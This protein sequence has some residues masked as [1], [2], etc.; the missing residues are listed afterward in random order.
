MIF[1]AA[2][3][4]LLLCAPLPAQD[5][6][7]AVP[8]PAQRYLDILSKRPQPGTLFER[9]Y[10]AWLE[11]GTV[12]EMQRF[13]EAQAAATGAPATAH[14]ILAIFHAH[15]GNDPEAL[16]C[17][18]TALRL[19]PQNAGAWIECSRIEARMLDFAAALQS[20]DQ[21]EGAKPQDQQKAEIGKLRGRALLRL[22][23]SDEALAV[24][25]ALASAH[26]DDEDLQEE[27]ID[28]FV[29]EGQ[30]EAALESARALV[31]RSRDPAAKI[32]R[33]LR[34]ADV[35]L[36]AERRD[37]ALTMLDSAFAATG[38]DS[39]IEGDILARIDRLFR[40][41]D[42]VSGLQ[43]HLAA[44][45]QAHPQRVTLAW[46]HAL[47]LAA[48]GQNDAALKSARALLQSNPGRRDLRDGFLDLLDSLG[49]PGEA[50]EQARLVVAQNPGDKE[51]LVR[52]A[53]LQHRAGDDSA[54]RLTLESFLSSAAADESAHLRIAR[55]LESW[56]E[57]P[58]K[59]DS[60]A[61]KAYLRLV[62]TFPQSLSAQEAHAHYLHRT[63]HRE[64]AI[65]IWRRM[66]GSAVLE[67]LL[68]IAQALQARLESRPALDVLLER[69]K[70]FSAQPRFL[71]LMVHL[72]MA[73]KEFG[74]ALP[75][76]CAH[77][78][79]MQDADGIDSSLRD[80]IAIVRSQEMSPA[81]PLID[82]LKAMSALTLQD[83]CLLAALLDHSG[84]TSEA[85]AL[86]NAAPA[87]DALIA[88][89]QL[90]HVFQS[91]Q[92]W[93][94][95][96]ETLRRVLELPGGRSSGNL[97]RMVELSRRALQPEQALTYIAEWKTV[98]PGAVAPWI[99]EARV[100][101]DLL[102]PEAALKALRLAL[103]KFPD[104]ADVAAAC[105][106]ACLNAGQA[107][108]AERIY[109]AMYEKTT[110]PASR[111]RML[112]PLA[113]A[114][115]SHDG[116]P[117]LLQNFVQRQKQNR[118]SAYPWLALAEIHRATDND[119][120]RRRCLYEASRLRPHDL[121]LLLEIAR[122][123][124]EEGLTPEAL[125]T[126]EAA[127]KLDKTTQT[128]EH[129]A[130]LQIEDGDPDIGYRMLFDLADS[131][132]DARAVEQMALVIGMKGDWE[133]VSSFL[134]PLLEKHP[135][136]Y[137]L[138]YLQA[139]ALEEAG[140]EPEAVQAFLRVLAMHE[141]L[142]SSR[143]AQQQQLQLHALPQ[144]LPSGT[145]DWLA[146][147]NIARTAYSYREER[148]H[149][150]LLPP[151]SGHGT[152]SL[153]ALPADVTESPTFALV[154][155]LQIT[156]VWQEDA[157]PRLTKQLKREGVAHA[158]LLLELA[159]ES[160]DF[161]VC[162]EM[163]SAHPQDAALHAA[164]L[165]DPASEDDPADKL[166]ACQR[167]FD[168][169]KGRHG[170]LALCAADTA[171]DT[172]ETPADAAT[173]LQLV[174]DLC[175]AVPQPQ[176]NEHLVLQNLLTSQ[177]RDAHESKQAPLVLISP[178]QSQTIAAT[179]RRWMQGMD[180]RHLDRMESLL[181]GFFELK[182]W[183]DVIQCL[184]RM[185]QLAEEPG[186]P[187]AP[188]RQSVRRSSSFE[189]S[190]LGLEATSCHLPPFVT[191]MLMNALEFT[192]QQADRR[193]GGNTVVAEFVEAMKTRLA[194][195]SEPRLKFILSML[196]G[197]GETLLTEL[198]P[199][200]SSPEAT[201]E[202]FFTAGWIC[203]E[204]QQHEAA[205][206]RFLKAYKTALTPDARQQAA[207]A[208]L[209]HAKLLGGTGKEETAVAAVQEMMRLALQHASTRE[210][211]E[212]LAGVMEEYGMDA[213][214][215]KLRSSLP[216]LHAVAASQSTTAILNPYSQALLQRGTVDGREALDRHLSQNNISGALNEARRVVRALTAEWLDPAR[217]SAETAEKLT[218]LLL[219]LEVQQL[220]QTLL[221]GIRNAAAN[222]WKPR[223][224]HAA[225][226]DMQ[227]AHGRP[228]QNNDGD[229]TLSSEALFEHAVAGYIT[230]LEANPHA[231]AA[232]QRLVMLHAASDA[233]TALKHWLLLP[234]TQQHP[235]LLPLT[236]QISGSD[237]D[238]ARSLAAA[239]LV[240]QWIKNRPPTDRLPAR[241]IALIGEVLDRVQ[242]GG[243]SFPSWW[244]I[245]DND[246]HP[247]PSQQGLRADAPG[248]PQ[249]GEDARRARNERRIAHDALC[250]AMIALPELAE[251][252]FA[253]LAGLAMHEGRNIEETEK[254]AP[255]ILSR[256]ADRRGRSDPSRRRRNGSASAIISKNCFQTR[257]RIAMPSPAVFAT[258]SAAARGDVQM[259]EGTLFPIILKTEGQPMLDFCRGYAGL[260]MAGDQDFPKA[261]AE[262]LRP[263]S[264][265]AGRSTLGCMAGEIVRL[266][267]ARKFTT[268]L[269]DFIIENRD[270]TLPSPEPADPFAARPEAS[271]LDFYVQVL[272][273]R[274]PE[275]LPRFIRRL[276]SVWVSPEAALRQKA[277]EK[278][279]ETE[280][281]GSQPD[282]TPLERAALKYR[283]WLQHFINESEGS[284]SIVATALEEDSTEPSFWLSQM[285]AA[286]LSARVQTP[287]EFIRLT[288]ALGFLDPA[289][290]SHPFA[291]AR[292]QQKDLMVKLA[293]QCRD[294]Q[295]D[296]VINAIIERLGKDHPPS[297]TTHW[298]QAMLVR[299]GITTLWLDG[300]P[301]K[302]QAA[303]P[304][305]EKGLCHAA[306]R[307]LLV[308]HAAEIA[309][310]PTDERLNLEAFLKVQL[311]DFPH[312]DIADA[313]FKHAVAPILK[314][315]SEELRHQADARLACKTWEEF[316]P[317]GSSPEDLTGFLQTVAADDPGRARA[318]AEHGL[319]LL[320]GCKEQ[321][322]TMGEGL[323]DTPASRYIMSLAHVPQLLGTSLALAEKHGLH[324]S[325]SW[326]GNECFR[327]EEALKKPNSTRWVFQNTPFTAAA[328]DFRDMRVDD[329][330]EPT[331]LARIIDSLEQEQE[332][333]AR[334][335]Q[336]LAGQPST[337]GTQLLLALL[338]RDP[339]DAK[340][341][342]SFYNEPHR[343]DDSRIITFIRQHRDDFT[344]L[345]PET[346]TAVLALFQARIPDLRSRSAADPRLKASLQPLI[347]AD[348]RQFE[349]DLQQFLKL[350]S[351]QQ[352]GFG[353]YEATQRGL[354]FLDRLAP[355]DKARAVELLDHVSKLM[356]TEEIIARSKGRLAPP[357]QTRIAQ[358][359]QRAAATPELFEEIMQRANE[360][361]A[362]GNP[363]WMQG[364]LTHL[365]DLQHLQ[366]SPQRFVSLL[367]A[368]H[369][370]DPAATFTPQPMPME[371]ERPTLLENWLPAMLQWPDLPPLLAKVRPDSFGADLLRLLLIPGP[372]DQ[373]TA[374]FAV[375]HEA[376]IAALP[377]A[378]QKLIS[379]LLRRLGVDKLPPPQDER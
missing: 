166:A 376:E 186:L 90:S 157:Q 373:E 371:K 79:L 125:R 283:D 176:S 34:L 212:S 342:R 180:N 73:N 151:G 76:A 365:M 130:R 158:E 375:K 150:A 27:I 265:S 159:R 258:W 86:L 379:E 46:Q 22:G 191:G 121:T 161:H 236:R 232:R 137:R 308:R 255:Q 207:N 63:G 3:C 62:A 355:M 326:C 281:N 109:L 240:T 138:H 235:L 345:T 113:K 145:A 95:A 182:A 333:C 48:T 167:C 354:R 163:L 7:P 92:D 199:R 87:Q 105:A 257:N 85:Q 106:T 128:R 88:L 36:L 96:A 234:A 352:A 9:F 39:W 29:D 192:R 291:S 16:L 122:S 253:P 370:L 44:M 195:I 119:E 80:I 226:L 270:F 337:F 153:I 104:A 17:Y 287:E 360:C 300:K 146:L 216:A 56:E 215:E 297:L 172:A 25:K 284:L 49:H 69:E 6:P 322:S 89:S 266:W 67:D 2:F 110:D 28:L 12:A 273:S 41:G 93:A 47:L 70:D 305:S 289:A 184:Q 324:Q 100:H 378:Q 294:I 341:R 194:A 243:S 134:A 81:Q 221:L 84:K 5:K 37:E 263:L 123:E 313:A 256:P 233:G 187:N 276:R 242:R 306:F 164:W 317:A 247:A 152:F 357:H 129:I 142:P 293:W 225:L 274:E 147:P 21:A 26:S 344:R 231:H 91:H 136:D 189:V 261:A 353:E 303:D 170:Y 116:L 323:P 30:F 127:A 286:G 311:P 94:K 102:H 190:P 362:T 154:H 51:L 43:K 279:R 118:V 60:P 336:W 82:E 237:Q 295:K 272:T 372:R 77:L 320:G 227:H 223:L 53:T 162:L 169:F 327:F 229:Q 241:C 278:I 358:W 202:D 364:A 217:Q 251:A 206:G 126:L 351:L 210:A 171:Y 32:M 144:D 220:R 356:A 18:Q 57:P 101:E 285:D 264:R 319:K 312:L 208:V 245:A 188:P 160:S 54:A 165:L 201:A 275:A 107:E 296:S 24:W 203:Q 45:S 61:A 299:A 338:H 183:D 8:A 133:H 112:A 211:K 259:L 228:F 66:A 348:A 347:D 304:G 72:L 124:E 132:M 239:R 15:R 141:E 335:R 368:A 177:S 315:K 97:Q 213:E 14:L 314:A 120:E 330:Y 374:A 168:M 193:E 68:R 307:L 271:V 218:Q 108:E 185:I 377:P 179:L 99:T 268:P 173:W 111:L 339:K 205:L 282:Y 198:Q 366:G 334:I 222:G 83:R 219:K 148:R 249:L 20:L 346:S 214:A 181:D 248:Q 65:A 19:S 310:M 238:N 31:Q 298:L 267:R 155:L 363:V 196:C 328:P 59:A 117:K 288:R 1:R 75:C 35:L 40:M 10:A 349:S 350:T 332:T 200:L 42:D 50:V 175:A 71:A 369:M 302:L 290:K 269:D 114:A 174:I 277:F 33:Q 325:L 197:K 209:Y 115:Q 143:Q 309:A 156:S 252:G 250:H 329:A 224:E 4:L 55:L 340:A 58:A 135:D 367:E 204:M 316:N 318:V 139:V 260:L 131:K 262:W 254:L 38:A 74:R 343:P 23:K 244:E 13:L 361:G 149:A 331:M 280:K 246:W 98:S 140:H 103:R 230:V 64:E 301:V 11:E 321:R 292:Q 52:L 178:A 78:R 359:L